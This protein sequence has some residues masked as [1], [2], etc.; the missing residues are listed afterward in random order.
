MAHKL[1]ANTKVVTATIANPGTIGAQTP[2]EVDARG[3][4]RACFVF[5][6]GTAAADGTYD[7]K[8]QKAATTGGALADVTDA[9]LAQV[10]KAAGDGKIEVIDI[11]V[12]GDKP[13]LKVTAT[14]ATGAFP[15]A[16]ICVLYNGSGWRPATQSAVQV[17]EL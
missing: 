15:N 6:L 4:D 12:P 11:P 5:N 7:A 16:I 14:T 17:I 2:V 1:L 13:F 8:I 10:T 9:A 3:W